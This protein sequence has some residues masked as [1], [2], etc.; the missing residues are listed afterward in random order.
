MFE[1][2]LTVDNLNLLLTNGRNTEFVN[3][4]K[5]RFDP[6]SRIDL[7]GMNACRYPLVTL[8]IFEVAVTRFFGDS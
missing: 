2:F 4:C 6:A 7:G 5:K 3:S 8:M 1:P